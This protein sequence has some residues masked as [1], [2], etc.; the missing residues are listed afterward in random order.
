MKSVRIW[1]ILFI[2]VLIITLLGPSFSMFLGDGTKS[3]AMAYSTGGTLGLGF[4]YLGRPI[5]PQLL[6]GGRTLILASTVS[7][8]ISQITGLVIGLW[9]ASTPVGSKII[10]FFLDV[11]LIL[12]MI[13]VSLAYYHLAGSSIYATIP[14]AILLTTPF[15]SRFYHANAKPLLKAPFYQQ[16]LVAGD[17]KLK[18]LFREVIPVM[19]KSIIN[20]LGLSVITSIYLLSTVTFLGTSSTD[21]GFMWPTMVS[22]NLPGLGLNIWASLAPIIAI[23]LLTIPLNIIID[24]WRRNNG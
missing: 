17:S 11:L 5:A 13:A 16:A 10:E 4:D 9:L 2:L 20:D 22:R 7:A 15:N 21:K 14:I 6:S 12:P 19:A 23:G 8:I 3:S 18:A 24:S 1:T